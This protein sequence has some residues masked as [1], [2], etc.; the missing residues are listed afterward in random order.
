[1]LG[2]RKAVVAVIFAWFL[3]GGTHTR[4]LAADAVSV[5]L[6]RGALETQGSL[7]QVD[8]RYDWSQRWLTDGAWY[9]G[10]YSELSLD[11]LASDQ[12]GTKRNELFGIGGRGVLRYQ[13]Y[14]P[15]WGSVTPFVEAGSG[16]FLFTGHRFGGVNVSTN[17][18]FGSILGMGVRFGAQRRFEL[19]YRFMHVSNA[20]IK[21]P[22]P[23]LDFNV[24]YFTYYFDR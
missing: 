10:G 3:W 12:A 5:A 8:L 22:N 20:S 23:G 17:L 24:V 9:L 18:Q 6:G 13:R 14:R 11:Y 19:S 1:M 2:C 21:K 16:P 4:G 7:R 15:W